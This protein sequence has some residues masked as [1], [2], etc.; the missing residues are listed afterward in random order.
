MLLYDPGQFID[1]TIDLLIVFYRLTA[2]EAHV[3]YF[4]YQ[5]ESLANIANDLDISINTVRTHLNHI[6]G[7]LGVHSQA[8]L[9]Q[10]VAN[11]LTV[12]VP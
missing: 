7:K 12:Q 4:L 11:G 10:L 9:V 6:F 3:T 8:E 5:G 1:S 2:A